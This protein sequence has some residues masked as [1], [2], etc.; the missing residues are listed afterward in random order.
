MV[1]PTL[2]VWQVIQEAATNFQLMNYYGKK[3]LIEPTTF[4]REYEAFL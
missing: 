3:T 4:S 2:V 1:L